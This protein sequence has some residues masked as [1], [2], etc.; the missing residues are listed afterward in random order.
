MHTVHFVLMGKGGVG[1]SM[2]AS[3][4]AQFLSTLDRNLFCADTDPTNMTFAHYKALNVQHYNIS[5]DNLKVD[6]RKFDSLINRIAEHEGDCVVD[7][8]CILS[9]YP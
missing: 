9:F 3:I 7:Y 8:W 6:T 1:K 4:L 5:D 2:V